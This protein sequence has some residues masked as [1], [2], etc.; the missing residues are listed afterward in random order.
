MSKPTEFVMYLRSTLPGGGEFLVAATREPTAR[1]IQ[2]M[3]QFL[4]VWLEVESDETTAPPP[5]RDGPVSADP[6]VHA[7]CGRPLP[8]DRCARHG[9][10]FPSGRDC[11]EC[12][13]LGL[14]QTI[15]PATNQPPGGASLGGQS[16]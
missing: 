7:D 5:H 11:R 8:H 14:Q 15:V 13:A 3:Q 1:D 10:C 12:V 2:K 16:R 6:A 9:A 4:A